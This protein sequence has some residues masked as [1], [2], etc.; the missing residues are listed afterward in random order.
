MAVW[1]YGWLK[2]GVCTSVWF[3]VQNLGGGGWNSGFSS[4]VEVVELW[5]FRIAVRGWD[6]GKQLKGRGFMVEVFRFRVGILVCVV[7]GSDCMVHSLYWGS[8]FSCGVE[9]VGL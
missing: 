1:I 3:T 6:L 4:G 8:E 2:M 7:Y 5:G 9:V